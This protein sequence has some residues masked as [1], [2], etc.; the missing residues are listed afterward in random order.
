MIIMKILA[1]IAVIY[2]LFMVA[3][4]IGVKCVFSLGKD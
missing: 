4:W 1:T 3:V 2:V